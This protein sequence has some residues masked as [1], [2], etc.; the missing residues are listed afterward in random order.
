MGYFAVVMCYVFGIVV[1]SMVISKRK[2]E[3]ADDFVVAGRRLPM[4]VL[5][6]TLLATWCGGGGITGSASVIYMYG[7][8]VGLL[9]FLG[10]P[11]GIILLYFIA[12]NVRKTSKVTIPEIFEARYGTGA[13]ILSAVCVI[14]AYV[15]IVATQFKASGHIMSLITGIDPDVGMVA[16]AIVVCLITVAG[17]MISVAYTDA[18]SALIMVGGFILAIPALYGITGGFEATLAALPDAK[19]TFTGGL[20]P[21]ALM[22]YMIP[23][24]AL[25]LGDQNMMQRFAS[26][27]DSSEAKKSN[28]GMFIAEV[29]VIISTVLIVTAGIILIPNLDA[30]SSANIIFALA[31]NH[32]PFVLG[33]A[34]IAAGVSFIV[35]TADSFLLSAATNLTY[36]LW[37]KFIKQD[38]TDKEKIRFLRTMIVLLTICAVVF[39]LFFP[40]II[41]LQLTAYA[42]YGAAITP[43]LLFA[44]FSKK[45]TKAGGIAGILT[46]AAITLVWNVWL[47]VPGGIQAAIISVPASVAAIIFV[48]SFTKNKDDSLNI[49]SLYGGE[50]PPVPA[51]NRS[52]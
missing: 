20:S 14:I 26:A 43:A 34:V 30:K 3:N 16:S 35:T 45:V 25:I 2:L 11:I 19:A 18:M 52:N 47:K 21:M 8:W 10:A 12:G 46:G 24:I 36:D 50:R 33:A 42:M 4:I 1:F 29:T 41:T 44:L 38:A 22:G 31:M 28:I 15:G 32:L 40:T 9:H 6:G 17:G 49:E 37:G 51:S 5:V 7:P 23:I 48:S 27:K 13:R 39:T